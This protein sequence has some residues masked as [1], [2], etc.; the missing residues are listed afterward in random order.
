MEL[1]MLCQHGLDDGSRYIAPPPK[2]LL[3]G[4]GSSFS[5]DTPDRE[6]A[7]P[8]YSSTSLLQVVRS[9]CH[10]LHPFLPRSSPIRQISAEQAT[11]PVRIVQSSTR[12]HFLRYERLEAD[13]QVPE[14]LTAQYLPYRSRRWHRQVQQT[15]Y[16]ARHRC[17]R[18]T[19]PFA[20]KSRWEWW[21]VFVKEASQG[22]R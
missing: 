12:S 9:D 19:S 3:S 2:D 22:V 5:S 10:G 17:T 8:W 11:A 1:R 21:S 14:S 15:R 18:Y 13:C 6:T 16:E 4:D 7:S 20:A